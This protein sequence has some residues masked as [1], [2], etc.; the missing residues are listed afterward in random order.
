MFMEMKEDR[1]MLPGII[2]RMIQKLRGILRED[3]F[4]EIAAEL[5][6]ELMP[7]AVVMINTYDKVSGLSQLRAIYADA[8][9][10]KTIAVSMGTNPVGMYMPLSPEMKSI[11]LQGRLVQLN[12]GIHDMVAGMISPETCYA[13]E[14]QFNITDVYTIGLTCGD[15]LLGNAC[16]LARGH[17]KAID[18]E[19]I[20]SLVRLLARA[21]P[22]RSLELAPA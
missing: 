3:M 12:G 5:L 19:S 6:H 11:I 7:H 14:K 13:M 16:F 1:A 8:V 18:D 10:L 22:D 2:D 9:N 20:Q 4:F 21:L 17:E 15:E